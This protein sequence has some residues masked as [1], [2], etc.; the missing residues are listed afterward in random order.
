MLTEV[1]LRT[2]HKNIKRFG[3]D[4]GLPYLIPLSFGPSWFWDLTFWFPFLNFLGIGECS[5]LVVP[6][7]RII[8][9][10]FISIG[11]MEPPS[12]K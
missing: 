8:P 3:Q 11:N 7:C 1:T 2:G 12:V 6:I 9:I 4:F 10:R 5:F